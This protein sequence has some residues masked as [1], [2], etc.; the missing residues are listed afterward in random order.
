MSRL[1]VYHFEWNVG[2]SGLKLPATAFSQV[3]NFPVS[4]YRGLFQQVTFNIRIYCQYYF[5]TIQFDLINTDA[6]AALFHVIKLVFFK[7]VSYYVPPF[8]RLYKILKQCTVI[9]NKHCLL[10]F[11]QLHVPRH[12]MICI[13]LRID[14]TFYHQNR[15]IDSMTRIDV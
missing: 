12:T 8:I 6:R 1:P 7:S 14:Y 4:N 10:T 9:I 2:S 15:C 11:E 3:L 5:F 13:A